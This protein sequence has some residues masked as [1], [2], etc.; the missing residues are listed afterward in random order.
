[1]TRL[2]SIL[3]L[4]LASCASQPA[5]PKAVASKTLSKV[6]PTQPRALIFSNADIGPLFYHVETKPTLE[7]NWTVFCIGAALPRETSI[8]LACTNAQSFFRVGWVQ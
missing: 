5:L 6:A 7:S 3:L 8:P 4:L 2:S 1:M